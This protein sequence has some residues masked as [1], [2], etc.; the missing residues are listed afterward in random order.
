LWEER[1]QY[2]GELLTNIVD[3]LV[4]EEKVWKGD[5]FEVAQQTKTTCSERGHTVE[6]SVSEVSIQ[7]GGGSSGDF[8]EGRLPEEY[9]GRVQHVGDD[10]KGDKCKKR[11]TCSETRYVRKVSK[12]IV[13]VL[14]CYGEAG[15]KTENELQIREQMKVLGTGYSLRSIIRH[16]GWAIQSGHYYACCKNLQKWCVMNDSTLLHASFEDVSHLEYDDAIGV[17]NP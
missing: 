7:L 11:G 12:Y 3:T 9:V 4:D 1:Q 13:I 15:I 14:K 16:V 8:L 2:A 17:A 10:Y 5:R 6:W